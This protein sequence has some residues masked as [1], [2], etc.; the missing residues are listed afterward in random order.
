[1]HGKDS[2]TSLPSS[3]PLPRLSSPVPHVFVVGHIFPKPSK[4]G[5]R[6]SDRCIGGPSPP[7]VEEMITRQHTARLSAVDHARINMTTR[8]PPSTGEHT[9][10]SR[11]HPHP[12][13]DRRTFPSRITIDRHQTST[14]ASRIRPSRPPR[15]RHCSTASYSRPS[16]G[17]A[18]RRCHRS[19]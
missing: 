11:F 17:Q 7:D 5:T 1:M 13:Q 14:A 4:S 10:S 6:I 16:G 8:T 2:S 9:E 19:R 12:T 15:T 3:L 18:S